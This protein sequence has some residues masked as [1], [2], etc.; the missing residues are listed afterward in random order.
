MKYLIHPNREAISGNL[1]ESLK[2]R[3][4]KVF[5]GVWSPAVALLVQQLGFDGIYVSGS[6]ISHCQGYPD[7]GFLNSRDFSDFIGQ[8]SA[9]T[10]LP[11]LS[12]ADTGF[13][14]PINAI[15]ALRD[16]ILAGANALHIEDQV[17]PKKCGHLEGKTLVSIESMVAK[18]QALVQMRDRWQ[19]D[20][21]IV[22]RTDAR[23]VEGPDKALE[24]ALRYVDAGADVIFP[25]AL[26]SPEEFELWVNK[27]GRPILANVTEFGKTP[28]LTWDQWR[29]LG[30]T[31][32]IYPVSTLRVALGACEE[33]L[34]EL[35]RHQTQASFLNRMMTRQR[36]Y[37][38]T[39]Y[40][41]Y[42]EWDRNLELSL[43]NLPGRSK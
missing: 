15:R 21:I 40:E 9:V 28:L 38:L 35:R 18:I 6:V 37:E 33:F 27:V 3:E 7:I 17:L 1:R 5:I 14:E 12:D 2:R 23:S 43:K 19:K 30:V 16:Y 8:V 39:Q 26:E 25:E 34:K 36:L 31:W 10:E 32:L 11:I 22:A 20:F 41:G 24:R 29:Q 42:Q 4:F 13:G